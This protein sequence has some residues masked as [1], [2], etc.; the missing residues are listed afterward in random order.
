MRLLAIALAVTTRMALAATALNGPYVV[1]NL[2]VVE[3]STRPDGRVEGRYKN[4]GACGFRQ[5]VKVL[6][7][8]FEG[9]VLVASVTV[10]QDGSGCDVQG[11]YPFLAVF[12]DK[13]FAGTLRL[14]EGCSSRA[15]D[16]KRLSGAPAPRVDAATNVATK[17]MT[18]K[19][20]VLA[21]ELNLRNAAREMEQKNYAEAAEQLEKS[22][23]FVE[24]NAPAHTSLGEVLMK[25]RN[26]PEA[27]T[28][29]AR[30]LELS[31]GRE[32]LEAN[33]NL[34]CALARDGRN[35][36]A[37][38]ALRRAAKAGPI[39]VSQLERDGDLENLRSDAEF[40]RVLSEAKARGAKKPR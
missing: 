8:I 7:G 38:E 39:S 17:G 9:D 36:E 6:S 18:Q 30:A 23:A 40:Q 35:P 5:D 33:Y 34:A 16:G 22:L 31:K 28:H 1:S 13:Q 32:L 3:F 25:L 4:G 37:I 19:Q 2:G 11:E 14:K 27:I 12:H 15:L 26:Y 29:Y 21:A 24:P 10:C 20:I